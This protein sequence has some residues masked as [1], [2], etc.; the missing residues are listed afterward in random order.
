MNAIDSSKSDSQWEESSL[1]ALVDHLLQEHHPYTRDKLKELQPLLDKVVNVHG[2]S[3]P[4]LSELRVL[5]DRLRNDMDMHL[6]KEEHILFPYICALEDEE[7]VSVPHFG[8]VANP[9][10]MMMS[11]HEADDVILRRMLEI[12]C[13]FSPPPGACA[14]YMALYLGLHELVS[15]LFRHM[16]LENDILFPKAIETEKNVL[17]SS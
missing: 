9:I 10:R 6:M 15:D 17:G 11:E 8:T 5:Y 7:E 16:H 13:D 1:T 14:S 2:A 4:E 3:H 12:T